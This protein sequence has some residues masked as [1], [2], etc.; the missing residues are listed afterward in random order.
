M[1]TLTNEA[2]IRALLCYRQP[3]VRAYLYVVML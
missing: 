2:V 1:L 3:Y